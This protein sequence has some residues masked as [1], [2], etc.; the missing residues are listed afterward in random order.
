MIAQEV[1]RG[2]RDVRHYQ[3]TRLLLSEVEMLDAPTPLER[4]EA[5]ARVF[6]DCRDA[7]VT[8]RS[9]IDCLIVAT[10]LAHDLTIVHDDRDFEHIRRVLPLKTLRPTRSSS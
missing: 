9:S 1:L 8:P 3:L 4:F 7:G 2:T 10:A 5:A 6:L